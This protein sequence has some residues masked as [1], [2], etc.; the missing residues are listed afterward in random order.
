MKT[1]R[2]NQ[3]PTRIVAAEA[4]NAGNMREHALRMPG[5]IGRARI[6]T[7]HMGPQRTFHPFGIRV[8]SELVELH[9][10]LALRLGSNLTNPCN[11]PRTERWK[12]ST[13][14]DPSANHRLRKLISVAAGGLRRFRDESPKPADILFELANDK[15]CAVFPRSFL[16]C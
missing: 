8:I 11:G 5:N 9:V 15:V 1:N 2:R 4:K 6:A 7:P 12:R 3:I 16:P 10:A 13:V 14:G